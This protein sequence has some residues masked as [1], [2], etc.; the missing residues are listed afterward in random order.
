MSDPLDE[1]LRDFTHEVDP[2]VTLAGPG[3][4]RRRAGRRR[5]RRLRAGAAVALVVAAA[6][7]WR[8]ALPDGTDGGEASPPAGVVETEPA[9]PPPTA[10]PWDEKLLWEPA[11][12]EAVQPSMDAWYTHCGWLAATTEASGARAEASYYTGRGGAVATFVT[13]AF[14]TAAEAKSAEEQL[15]SEGK[16]E[17]LVPEEFAAVPEEYPGASEDPLV[18]VLDYGPE[19]ALPLSDSR[20][21]VGREGERLD[22]LRV[23]T[24]SSRQET[25]EAESVWRGED[26]T[27]TCLRELLAE[28]AGACEATAHRAP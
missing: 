1:R 18:T 9:P 22:V 4:A 25:E 13:L 28:A 27:A 6:G 8:F 11:H 26:N 20:L 19:S 2:A 15:L 23:L 16:C 14:A 10:L 3:D 21:Y 17:G 7:V 5:A 24:D 12:A